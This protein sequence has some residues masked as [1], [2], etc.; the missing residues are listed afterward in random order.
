MPLS[1]IVAGPPAGG[2]GTQ[3]EQIRDEFGLVH[4]STGDMLRRAASDETEIGQFVKSFLDNGELVPDD[5]IIDIVLDRIK[6]HDCQERGWLMDGFPRTKRQAEALTSHGV[7]CDAF[8]L[9]YVPDSVLVERV[10]GR[11]SDPETGK[12]YHLKFDPPNDDEIRQRLVQRDDDTVEKVTTR[13]KTYHENM[14]DIVP[15]YESV[16]LAV[17]GDRPKEEIW[18]EIK[19]ILDEIAMDP[20][21]P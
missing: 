14:S 13:I 9:L 11:R 2:K 21:A 18:E 15:F 6:E 3:C 4:L 17:D 16:M 12:I 5:A 10:A 8:I 1:V 7:R 20:A 19:S